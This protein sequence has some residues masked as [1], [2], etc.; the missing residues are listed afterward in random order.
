MAKISFVNRR[1]QFL[2]S[3]INFLSA[4]KIMFTSR[5]GHQDNVALYLW[6]ICVPFKDGRK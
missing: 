5:D 4:N 1:E 6:L 3:S 2:Y